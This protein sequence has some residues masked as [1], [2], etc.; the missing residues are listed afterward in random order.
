MALR[1]KIRMF[2]VPIN[3]PANVL[4]D[5]SGVVKNT[6]IPESTLVKK[7]NAINYHA[8]P[9]RVADDTAPKHNGMAM[10]EMSESNGV[11]CIVMMIEEAQ[12]LRQHL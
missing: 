5:N 1:Y 12:L 7:H 8:S 10:A 11:W 3:R 2:G 4:C 9:S 6:S